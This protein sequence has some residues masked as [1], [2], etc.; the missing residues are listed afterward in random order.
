MITLIYPAGDFTAANIAIK[1]QAL[2]YDKK[3]KVYIVP[4]HFGRKKV[5]V[6]L[7]IINSNLII[8][9]IYDV[10]II[11][12][13]T[14]DEIRYALAKRK[15][16]ISIIPTTVKWPFQASANI[17]LIKYQ[18]SNPQ[19]LIN[20]I[21]GFITDYDASKTTAIFGIAL[22]LLSLLML[23]LSKEKK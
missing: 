21:Q 22:V 14:R 18:R 1:L 5:N 16:I 13:G 10:D 17:K 20:N 9:F 7:N 12:V 19:T 8:F 3:I 23:A 11:D 2:A 6:I 15:K 4:K